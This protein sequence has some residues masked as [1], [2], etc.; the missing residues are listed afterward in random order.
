MEKETI[1]LDS[2]TLVKNVNVDILWNLFEQY[3]L[4]I[5]PIARTYRNFLT[6][7]QHKFEIELHYNLPT[8]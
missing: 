7:K 5:S 6:N 1:Y 2:D 4:A 3:D 8:L